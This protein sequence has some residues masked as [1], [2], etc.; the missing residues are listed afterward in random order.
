MGAFAGAVIGSAF[1][2][3]FSSIGAGVIGAV[4]GTMGGAAVRQKLY[5]ANNGKDRPGAFLEDVGGR[6]WRLPHRRS[7]SASSER[8][9]V[10]EKFDAIIVGAGQAGPP[11]AGR[12]TQAGQTV[13]VIERKLVGGT[14]VN[15]GCIPTKTLVASAHAAHAGPPRGRIRRRHRRNHHRHGRR[16]RP[17]KT[18]SCSATAVVSS[19]G[20]TAWTGCTFIRGHARFE[21]PHTISVDGRV[22]EADKIFLNVGGRA[23]APDMP[24]L[25]RHR[26]HDQCRI[27]EL[28]TV[29]EHLV[30]HRRQLYRAGVRPDVPP[31]RRQGDSRREGA[32]ADLHGRTRTSRRPS[33]RSWRP[34]ASTWSSMPTRSRFS[35]A[36]Q[37]FRGHPGATA[38]QPIVGTAPSRRGG[39]SAQHRRPRS[40]GRG[41]GDRRPRLHRRRRPVAHQRRTHLGDGGLQRPRRLHPH[42]VQRLRDR[43]G[44]PARRRPA[45]GQRPHHHLCAVHRSAAGPG[46]DDGRRGAQVGPKSVG[47]QAAR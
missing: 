15:Y 11:L 17:A 7:S 28:D 38:P 12:L 14:C 39:T 27:L 33:R 35:Q 13:A 29:P 5:D 23:V 45:P 21:D 43:R 6:R 32:A 30:D 44:E 37:R 10:A 19:R 42:V 22:L 47:G 16:S 34:R 18:R 26:L 9:R 2:H 46:R 36:R 20:W 25:V 31:V 24:G 8:R 3:T 1:F 4:L 40:R 41:R